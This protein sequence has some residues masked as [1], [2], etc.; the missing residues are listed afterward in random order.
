MKYFLIGLFTLNLYAQ[1]SNHEEVPQSDW[2][3]YSNQITSLSSN[4]T[5]KL[6][7]KRA[8]NIAELE[9]YYVSPTT[10]IVPGGVYDYIIVQDEHFNQIINNV[11]DE[12]GNDV[13]LRLSREEHYVGQKAYRLLYTNQPFH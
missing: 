4:I 13:V 1:L 10:N 12:K 11:K 9:I 8:Q 6:I 2:T 5:K 7:I 3:N